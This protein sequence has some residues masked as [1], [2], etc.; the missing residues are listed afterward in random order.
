[1]CGIAEFYTGS[2]LA[3]LASGPQSRQA[4]EMSGRGV[5]VAGNGFRSKHML[6]GT[7]ASEE[8]TC[9]IENPLGAVMARWWLRKRS[10]PDLID[11][12]PSLSPDEADG[13]TGRRENKTVL[14][15]NCRLHLRCFGGPGV[16]VS[17]YVLSLGEI[18]TFGIVEQLELSHFQLQATNPQLAPFLRQALGLQTV[19][20][21]DTAVDLNEL[22]TLMCANAATLDTLE[23]SGC[24]LPTLHIFSHFPWLRELEVRNATIRNQSVVL[25]DPEAPHS[26][27]HPD[28][29]QP[30]P[31]SA[32]KNIQ[33]LDLSGLR[34]HLDFAGLAECAALR[35]LNLSSSTVTDEDVAKIAGSQTLLDLFLSNTKV[36]DVSSL[37]NCESLQ[38][39]QL[40]HTDV[41]TAGVAGLADLEQLRLLDLS[42][43]KVDS[44]NCFGACNS[45]VNLNIWKTRVTSDGIRDLGA[46]RSLEQLLA[47]DNNI[48]DATA[49]NGCVSLRRL[50]LQST[51]VTTEGIAGLERLPVLED[52]NLSHTHVTDVSAFSRAPALTKLDLTS[53]RVTTEGLRALGAAPSLG[54]LIL[55]KSDVASLEALPGGECQ[56]LREITAKWCQLATLGGAE[57]IPHLTTLVATHCPFSDAN[58]LKDCGELQVLNLW[59]CALTQD[60]IARLGEC[61]TLVDVDLAETGI[62]SIAP[63]LTCSLLTSLVFYSTM[64]SF[65]DGIGALQ[66]LTRLD[67]SN[68]HITS[69]APL[70]ACP[71]LETLNVSDTDVTNDGFRGVEALPA[72]KSLMLS[73]TKV[74]RVGHLGRS[75]RELM[76]MQ[77]NRCPIT[78]DGLDGLDAALKLEKLGLGGTVVGPGTGCLPQCRALCKLNLKS[79]QVPLEELSRLRSALPKCRIGPTI[80]IFSV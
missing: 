18:L 17:R 44:V 29:V 69:L 75:C 14:L 73:S 28:G 2:P 19:R 47:G 10:V 74:T 8:I 40:A 52:L 38:T 51:L 15:K 22:L 23:M 57:R 31:L 7:A 53:S 9:A 70:A 13:S 59:A 32:F 42:Y 64:V 43:T 3:F 77:A 12:L 72:L 79:S 68:T 30:P 60:G 76:E 33:K 5:T 27:P 26:A 54:T 78:T 50:G 49:L 41:T 36:A 25:Q 61:R 37:R 45:L 46:A 34:S 80:A 66:R 20:L 58:V 1:M 35:V 11:A 71:L 39:L 63:V 6:D 48:D 56:Q 62:T 55:S 24:T 67:L 65:L 21:R 16:Q 4:S